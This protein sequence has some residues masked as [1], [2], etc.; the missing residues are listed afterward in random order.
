MNNN[1]L[2]DLLNNINPS[3]EQKGRMLNNI[4]SHA[5]NK[6]KLSLSWVKYTLASTVCLC[7]LI[8]YPYFS[9]TNLSSF[10]NSSNLQS[11]PMGSDPNQASN[12]NSGYDN[13]DTSNLQLGTILENSGVYN[14]TNKIDFL[15]TETN[16][17]FKTLDA[18]SSLYWLE[19]IYPARLISTSLTTLEL[20]IDSTTNELIVNIYRDNSDMISYTL[21][22]DIYVLKA[23]DH[24]YHISDLTIKFLYE[25]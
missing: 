3:S 24:Y 4:L 14:D 18:T 7:L 1:S 11:Q 15:I 20:D 22:P 25:D 6:K 2:N 12:N 23:H 21:Y 13:L 8:G 10:D 9:K 16:T 17:L 5:D 19:S